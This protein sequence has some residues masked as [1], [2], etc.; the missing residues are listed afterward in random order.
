MGH[1]PLGLGSGSPTKLNIG[2][3]Q[4]NALNLKTTKLET[5][6]RR[7]DAQVSIGRHINKS[8][9]DGGP[10]TSVSRAGDRYGGSSSVSHQMAHAKRS[11]HDEEYADEVH[12]RMRYQS[13]RQM[14]REKKAAEV[15]VDKA[16]DSQKSVIS[17]KT[18]SGYRSKGKKGI[19]RQ[20]QKVRRKK[21]LSYGSLSDKD[22]DY[23]SRI[24]TPHAKALTRGSRIGRGSRMKMKTDVDRQRRSGN[25]TLDDAKAMKKMI[26]QM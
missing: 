20:L 2:G 9:N 26:D 14:M 13:I 6:G 11:I 21:P 22:L 25:I 19:K 16:I 15:A 5:E 17:F 4:R 10:T 1:N 12:D 18:G 24:V 3:A 23:F 7:S 8:K